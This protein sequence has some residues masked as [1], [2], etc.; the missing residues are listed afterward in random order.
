MIQP[1][2]I[3]I[4]LNKAGDIE[5][6][7]ISYPNYLNRG[8]SMQLYTV[9][10]NDIIHFKLNDYGESPW[11]FSL[12]QSVMPLVQTR[13]ELNKI[14]PILFKAYAKPYRHFKFTP[15]SENGQ[16]MSPDDIQGT[17]DDMVDFLNES[18]EPDSDIVTA[19]GWNINAISS[20]GQGNPATIL[21]DI[22]EQMFAVLDVPKYFFKPSGTTD[23]NINRSD[24][25][26]V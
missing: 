19:D 25:N 13:M 18:V 5:A 3:S 20:P 15:P 23:L 11:G 8:S 12:L 10:P 17:I 9:S 21:D 14:I 4:A 26:A 1:E 7:N 24:Q 6:Y 22:D 16:Q 2:R